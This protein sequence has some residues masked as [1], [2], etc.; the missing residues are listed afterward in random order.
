M[1]PPPS[2][3]A[4]PRP[5]VRAS[6]TPVAAE[7]SVRQTAPRRD[8]YPSCRQPAR[9]ACKLYTRLASSASSTRVDI[10]RHGQERARI[11]LG[12]DRWCERYRASAIRDVSETDQRIVAVARESVGTVV[13][14]SSNSTATRGVPR[15]SGPTQNRARAL[16]PRY[17][18][19][20]RCV[21]RGFPHAA[22]TS[23]VCPAARSDRSLRWQD[24]SGDGGWFVAYV[25]RRRPTQGPAEQ[26]ACKSVQRHGHR[27]RDYSS[28][29]PPER[30]SSTRSTAGIRVLERRAARSVLV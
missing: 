16:P 12:F 11:R 26:D 7:R 8:R 13:F 2:S 3:L 24:R 15:S 29:L 18:R 27:G 9:A 21:N 19:G 25:R 22:A 5:R 10:S 1:R 17:R 6:S 23:T 20:L 14:A 28:R 4:C 30:S